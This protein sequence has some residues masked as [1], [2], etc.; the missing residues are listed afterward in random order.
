MN[1]DAV[2]VFMPSLKYLD[3]KLFTIQPHSEY[4]LKVFMLKYFPCQQKC[5]T[6]FVVSV[7]LIYNSP[8]SGYRKCAIYEGQSY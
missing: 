7:P 8:I 4:V 1:L 5:S 3:T 2:F 6:A